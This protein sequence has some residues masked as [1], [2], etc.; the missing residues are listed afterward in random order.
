[1]RLSPRSSVQ[2]GVHHTRLDRRGRA[3]A[4]AARQV[5]RPLPIWL[6]RKPDLPEALPQGTRAAEQ[7]VSVVRV[8]HREQILTRLTDSSYRSSNRVARN[9]TAVPTPYISHRSPSLP[10]DHDFGS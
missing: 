5:R 1:M 7:G 10:L 2:K 6:R 3:P 9:A 8:A 4:H